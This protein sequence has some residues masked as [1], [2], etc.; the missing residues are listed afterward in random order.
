MQGNGGGRQYDDVLENVGKHLH[1]F[2]QNVAAQHYDSTG[3]R[4]TV[5]EAREIYEN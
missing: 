2:W 5:E 1:R 3:Q 4:I